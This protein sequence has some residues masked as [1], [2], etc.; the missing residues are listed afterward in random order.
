MIV[1][2][3]KAIRIIRVI[4]AVYLSI[5]LLSLR[6]IVHYLLIGQDKL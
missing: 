6:I 1:S 3:A 2:T 5:K 4:G